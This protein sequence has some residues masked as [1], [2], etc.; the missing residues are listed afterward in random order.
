[1][2]KIFKW[3]SIISIVFLFSCLKENMTSTVDESPETPKAEIITNNDKE[4]DERVEAEAKKEAER[5]LRERDRL[6]P[7]LVLRTDTSS[8]YS[9]GSS[10][11]TSSFTGGRE[12]DEYSACKSIC[13]RIMRTGRS[14]CY[15]FSYNIVEDMEDALFTIRNIDE[16]DRVNIDPFIFDAIL[17][18]DKRIISDLVEDEMSEGDL[19]S[20]LAWVALNDDIADVLEENDRSGNILEEAF[21]QL[22][23]FQE[24]ATKNDEL[25][26]INTGL[27]T[28]DDTFLF[29]ASDEE[30]ESA[31]I[32]AYDILS[33]NPCKEIGC[34]EK[35]LCARESRQR[36]YS[37]YRYFGSTRGTALC[38]TSSEDSRRSSRSG[39]CYVHGSSVWSYLYELIDDGEIKGA[40][41]ELEKKPLGVERCNSVCGSR[42]ST[43][44]KCSLFNF[45]DL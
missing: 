3:L 12:C 42:S 34:Q 39:F 17:T 1:M 26:G 37:S 38:R 19:K 21:K 28:D 6:K 7:N 33:S 41:D 29:L 32:M 45:T 35:I 18:A 23:K 11:S 8:R 10:S 30:N 14:R 4:E 40:P 27:I 15:R 16:A 25:A 20:F 2:L 9:S 31:F 22:G 5:S 36:S 13:D 43:N 44:T 24:G